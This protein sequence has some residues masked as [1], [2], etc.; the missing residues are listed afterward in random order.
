VPITFELRCETNSVSVISP[1]TTSFTAPL[2]D[3]T[4]DNTAISTGNF[5]Y[6]PLMC[7]LSQPKFFTD[8]S[9]NTEMTDVSVSGTTA[10][11][12]LNFGRSAYNT[13]QTITGYI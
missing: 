8:T 3:C 10:D 6:T 12:T 13:A 11:V 9:F 1:S 7:V 4:E 2:I 5:I